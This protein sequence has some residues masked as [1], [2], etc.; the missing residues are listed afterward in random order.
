MEAWMYYSQTLPQLFLTL[1]A[2]LLVMHALGS[3]G[4]YT[5]LRSV[6]EK[7]H[8]A[9]LKEIVPVVVVTVA[10]AVFFYMYVPFMQY[11]YLGMNMTM[12]P[13]STAGL[14]TVLI[15]F[16]MILLAI[17][18]LA[19]IEEEMFR[20]G[21]LEW[22]RIVRKSILFGLMHLLAGIP[23]AAAVALMVPG[24][25]FGFTYKRAFERSVNAD[26]MHPDHAHDEA[27]LESTAYHTAYNYFIVTV[28]L[29]GV[30]FKY[31]Q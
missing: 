10:I 1:L 9:M 14:K 4:S 27:L 31:W 15:F 2:F 25:Y 19:L 12:A 28:A 5:A 30:F 22:K 20:K 18:K 11:G 13:F 16:V 29:G 6:W 3:P 17:P 26:R 23:I 21:I 8:L 7:I 24:L